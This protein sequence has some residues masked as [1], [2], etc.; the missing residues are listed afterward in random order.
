MRV[1]RHITAWIAVAALFAATVYAPLF[2]VHSDGSEAP[3]VHAHLPELESFDV[4]S[5]VHMERPHS[6]GGARSLDVLTTIAVQLVHCDAIV[7][8]TFVA[9]IEP[10]PSHGFMPAASPR[11][12]AP[13]ALEFLTPRAPPA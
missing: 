7:Q 9:L 5:V 10:Q 6:H 3:L 8:S 13:P 4:E 2:H 1:K 11:A 12:H